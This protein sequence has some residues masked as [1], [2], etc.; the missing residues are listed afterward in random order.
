[1]PRKASNAVVGWE[2]EGQLKAAVLSRWQW[3]PLIRAMCNAQDNR[4]G[5]KTGL[6]EGSADVLVIVAPL[7]RAA[8]FEFKMP[9]KDAEPHQAKWLRDMQTCGCFACVVHSIEEAEAG[10]KR[11]QE[12]LLG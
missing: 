3:N 8:W 5:Y 10:L 9:G 12:G 1:M 7:G 2:N 6:G 4:H 11:A